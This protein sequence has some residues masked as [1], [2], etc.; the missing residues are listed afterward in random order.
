MGRHREFNIDDALDAAVKV[1]WEKGY[2][3]TSY[4]DLTQA[5]GVKRPGLYATFGNKESL[6]RKVV[7]RYNQ[8]YLGHMSEALAEPTSRKMAERILYG[9]VSVATCDQ[10][11]RGCLGVNGALAC[12]EDAEPVR[13]MLIQFRALGQKVIRERLVQFQELGD[14]PTSVDCDVLAGWLMT[15]NAGISVQAKAGFSEQQLNAV[16]KLSLAGWPT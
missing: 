6:F 9:T 1:F 14:L 4:E 5:T 8:Q 10:I 16:V 15:Q 3:G 13:E 2:E 12:S 7:E 11:C